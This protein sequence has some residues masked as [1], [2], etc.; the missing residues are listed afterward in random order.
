MLDETDLENEDDTLKVWKTSEIKGK[1]VKMQYCH[2][3]QLLVAVS[4]EP[5]MLHCFEVKQSSSNTFEAT[6]KFSTNLD[7]KCQI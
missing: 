3:S 7:F 2:Q 4:V 5:Y 6:L 1:I